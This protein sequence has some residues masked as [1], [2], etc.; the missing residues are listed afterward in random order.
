VAAVTAWWRWR[1]FR[2]EVAGNSMSPTLEAGDWALAVRPFRIRPGDVVVLE[3]PDRPGLELV[4][5][6]VRV[7]AGEPTDRAIWV[8]G[9]A[10]RSTDS[11][12]FGAVPRASIRGR[13]VLIWWPP[14]RRALL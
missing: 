6:V 9:D 11:R 4:K 7:A 3:H 2:I 12:S 14:R 13:V 10:G 1:P 8:E 5:R